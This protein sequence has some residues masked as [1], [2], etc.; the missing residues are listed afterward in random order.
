MREFSMVAR[1]PV[2]VLESDASS[3][4]RPGTARSHRLDA[5]QRACRYIERKMAAEDDAG[6]PGPVTLAE[7]GRA[8]AV[9]P[10]HLQRLFKQAMGVTPRQYADAC[11]VN[12][13]KSGLQQGDGVAAATYGAGFGSASRVYERAPQA[14]GMTPASYAKGGEGADIAYATAPSP[15]GRVLVAATPKGVCF[16]SIGKADAPLIEA[17]NEEFP[18]ARRIRKDN[19]ALSTALAAIL[20]HLEGR[21]P[22]IDLPLDIQATAFQQRV[23]EELRRIPLGETLTYGE[24][25][26]R[27]G[28]PTAARA[29]GRACATNPVAVVIPCHRAC[30]ADGSL[31]G[32]RWGKGVKQEL[33]T[34]EAAKVDIHRK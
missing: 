18:A 19:P 3:S 29:V 23:W 28:Q 22:H 12:R 32:Y 20:A 27:L 33:L 21:A 13:L 4:A 24:I 6:D 2:E 31:T 11:R 26:G 1:R 9:S 7:L 16:V 5:V 15:L 34:R 10:W 8:C 25:A 14:L 30:G 17:L